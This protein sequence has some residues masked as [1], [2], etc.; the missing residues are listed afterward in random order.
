[1]QTINIIDPTSTEFNRGSF[2]YA[3]YLCYNGL[4]EM[5]YGVHLMESFRSEDMDTILPADIHIITLW[6]YPQIEIALL[7]TQFIPF[8]FGTN[9]VYFVGYTPLIE[10]LGLRH[11]SQKLGFD[12]MADKTFLK[13]AMNSYSKYF[14]HFNRL[15]LS[16]CDMHIKDLEKGVKV[17]PLFTTYGCP[18]GCSFCPSSKNCGRSRTVLEI[19]EVLGLLDRCAELGI[20][21]IHFTDEDFFYDIARA[22]LIF[23]H[24]AGRGFHLIALGAAEAVNLY[25]QNYGTDVLESAGMEVIEIG[26]E[27]AGS[28]VMGAGKSMNDCNDLAEKQH[29][30]PFKIFW[31]V[32]TFFIGETIITLNATGQFM[33]AYGLEMEEVVG[34]LRTNGT[35]GGLGQFF[36]VYHGTPIYKVAKRDGLEITPRAVR[37]LPS[38]IPQSFLDAIIREIRPDNFDS[39]VPWLELYS[40]PPEDWH[41]DPDSIG[42]QIKEYISSGTST[43]EQIK[44][45]MAL[46][47]LA[48]MEVIL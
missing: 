28:D 24:L 19:Q 13:M 15:L 35:K 1:M 21:N 11:V 10:E 29:T 40:I 31:L 25:I 14:S 27:S 42:T 48:R 16:D 3:P 23:Q 7:L 44:K 41:P 4:K 45:A 22:H 5:Y 12:P 9:N 39:A 30:Y 6:S 34:R 8:E 46:A 47:I 20:Y 33:K 2:C 32:Q 36:Q 17:H 38:Y 26:F 37:L 43:Y 18:H